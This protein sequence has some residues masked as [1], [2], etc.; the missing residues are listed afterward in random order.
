MGEFFYNLGIRK[1]FLTVA[2]NLDAIEKRLIDLITL[3]NP[4]AYGKK[5][6]LN[7]IINIVKKK[8]QTRR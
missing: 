7:Y 3:K 2:Q 4:S 5:T 1:D 8:Q 6:F